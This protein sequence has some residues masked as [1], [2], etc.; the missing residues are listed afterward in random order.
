MLELHHYHMNVPVF[1]IVCAIIRSDHFVFLTDISGDLSDKEYC[2]YDT[3]RA[4]CP[5]DKVI[6]ITYAKYG[7]MRIGNCIKFGK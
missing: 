3:F 5:S 4:Q 2:L 1:V 7:A 6:L